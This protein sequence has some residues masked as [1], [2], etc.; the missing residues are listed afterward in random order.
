MTTATAMWLFK[1]FQSTVE[2]YS[3]AI[4]FKKQVSVDLKAGEKDELHHGYGAFYMRNIL[5]G[6]RTQYYGTSGKG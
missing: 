4:E 1:R 5:L 6:E 2:L 3:Q